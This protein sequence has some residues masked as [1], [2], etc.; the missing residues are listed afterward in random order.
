MVAVP[1]P[2]KVITEPEKVATFGS[3]EEYVKVPAAFDDGGVI[4]RGASP[5][6]AVSAVKFDNEAEP[7]TVPVTTVLKT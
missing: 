5:S 1:M 7:G 6:C 2:V 4:V 3:D